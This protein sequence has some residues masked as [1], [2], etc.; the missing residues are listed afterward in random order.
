MCLCE[1]GS[2]DGAEKM[3][4]GNLFSVVSATPAPGFTLSFIPFI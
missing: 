4:G 3:E 2:V 1:D